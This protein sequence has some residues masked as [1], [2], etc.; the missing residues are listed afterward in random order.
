MHYAHK[1]AILVSFGFP[2]SGSSGFE[3]LLV[4]LLKMQITWFTS[5]SIFR[6]SHQFSEGEY[7][8]FVLNNNSDLELADI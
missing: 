4:A 5:L 8:E 2:R 1:V 3:T 6:R 7:V